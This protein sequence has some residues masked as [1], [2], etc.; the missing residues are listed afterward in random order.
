MRIQVY[1]GGGAGG[2][3]SRAPVTSF[4]L[5]GHPKGRAWGIHTPS[6]LPAALHRQPEGACQSAS[7]RSTLVAFQCASGNF[8]EPLVSCDWGAWSPTPGLPRSHLKAPVPPFPS[9][10]SAAQVLLCPSPPHTLPFLIQPPVLFIL[11]MA[12]VALHQFAD[13]VASGAP[14]LLPRG[15]A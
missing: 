7:L 15:R 3:S 5:Q 4:L 2:H 10:P 6:T 1:L 14:F 9:L 8:Q 13:L 12:P 11:C